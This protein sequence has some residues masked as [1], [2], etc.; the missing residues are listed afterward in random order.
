ME[1]IVAHAIWQPGEPHWG[2]HVYRFE[3]YFWNGERY[4][5]KPLGT[6]KRKYSPTPHQEYRFVDTMLAAEPDVLTPSLR[7]AERSVDRA[8]TRQVS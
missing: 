4:V 7:W 1:G 6:T 5:S 3:R 8:S 2:A